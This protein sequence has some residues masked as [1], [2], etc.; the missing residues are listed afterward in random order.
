MSR[1]AD[2]TTG[3]RPVVSMGTWPRLTVIQERKFAGN[4]RL[5]FLTP[6]VTSDGHQSFPVA[7]CGR[8]ILNGN[9]DNVLHKFRFRALGE[10][11]EEVIVIDGGESGPGVKQA[12]PGVV[13]EP[14]R[15][16]GPGR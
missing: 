9:E 15:K 1:G 6:F 4:R 10:G 8:R 14:A 13:P 12:E 3:L 16:A 5:G 2:E 7:W 11:R